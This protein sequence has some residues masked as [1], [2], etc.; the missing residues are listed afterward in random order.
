MKTV[1]TFKTTCAFIAVMMLLVGSTVS[2]QDMD[3]RQRAL[4]W[5]GSLGY[6]MN[7][8]SLGYQHLHEP[9][10]NFNKPNTD[11]EKVNGSG[12][13]IY[14]GMIFEYLS[15]SWWGVQVRAS[16]E[17]RDATV[18]D[19]FATPETEFITRMSYLTFEPALRIDQHL[20]PN[21][22]FSAGP[23]IAANLA[24]YYD[25]K[26][27]VNG[28]VT[29]ADIQ[30]PDRS[31]VSLGA[32]FG[33]AYDIELLRG[34][35]NALF[36]SPF[37]D[38]T[39]IAA[40]R[41]AVTT[42]VQNSV[43]DIWSTQTYRV[44]I[45]VSWEKRKPMD[46]QTYVSP[47]TRTSVASPAKNRFYAILPDGNTVL[48][49]SVEGY[50]PIHPYVFFDKD[51]QEIPARYTKLSTTQAQ[52]FGTKDLGEFL[53]G[54]YSDKQT[55]VN[56]LMKVY[57]HV[58]NIFGD[59]M[60]SNPGVNLMLRSSD[61]EDREAQ[62][63]AN[64]IKRYLVNTF[65]IDAS[66]ITTDVAPPWEPSGSDLS[67]PEYARMIADENRRVQLVF[68]DQN[69][70][71]SIPY[72]I[73]DETSFDNNMIFNIEDAVSFKSWSVSI[74][75]EG[76]E[77][78]AGP[79]YARTASINLAPL[80]SGL[81]DGE[82][83][84]TVNITLADGQKTT[85]YLDFK[86]Y[87]GDMVKNANRYLMVFDYNESD[88]IWAF[89]D[90]L[91]KEIVHGMTTG[92]S[93]VIHGHTD[94][95]GNEKANQILSQAR[96]EKVKTI[97]VDELRKTSKTVKVTAVGVGQQQLRYTFDNSRPEGRMY[98]RNVFVEVLR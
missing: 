63:A 65:G 88:P 14:A 12:D 68:S 74:R 84:A 46:T 81:P 30:V 38:Y 96:A 33:T 58:L 35:N 69:M 93:V 56:E 78:T 66:R 94:V 41:K 97:V 54:E 4:R 90:Q 43:Q 98:N 29:D 5:G 9:F 26:A 92:N 27:N 25:F 80:V 72:T 79:F 77:L 2:A 10:P 7:E 59:R 28:P 18:Q 20:I 3:F 40:Q 55:N 83:K 1:T 76:R 24:G 89:E 17:M 50:F 36:L 42:D 53:K 45:R 73:T 87:H 64:N 16:F 37:F 22:S 31:V 13:G 75:G 57:Y 23:L 91:R 51:S 52:N 62:V 39:W 60:R 6:N 85:E 67:D 47:S 15:T 71:K 21:L 32:T 48:S 34:Q 95:I 19:I 44:G 82:F 49:K 61:P 8:A 70:Y 86:L 11:N